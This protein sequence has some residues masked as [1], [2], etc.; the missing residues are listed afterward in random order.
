MA[1]TKVKPSGWAFGEKLTSAQMNTLDTDHSTAIDPTTL[2]LSGTTGTITRI[3]PF[4]PTLDD[5]SFWVVS[6]ASAIA[7]YISTD[8]P[9]E[10][11]C[12][13]P[14]KVPHGAT[15]QAIR[16]VIHPAGGHV[17][18]PSVMPQFVLKSVSNGGAVVTEVS[19]VA[20]SSPDVTAY[21]LLHAVE[22]TGLSLAITNSAKRY[23][24]LFTA[25]SAS[26]GVAGC[27]VYHPYYDFTLTNL[28]FE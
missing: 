26:N 13:W 21:E 18:L 6:P 27:L 15:L 23:T 19:P 16:I 24:L 28:D 5:A 20:D 10:Q 1:Y 12:W 11:S 3:C 14:L 4:A 25:E 9:T 8:A 2:S 22:I 17:A 7:G